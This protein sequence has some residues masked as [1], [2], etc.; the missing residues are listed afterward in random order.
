MIKKKAAIIFLAFLF[1]QLLIL[2]GQA[3]EERITNG[4][5]ETGDFTGWDQDG[6]QIEGE[7]IRTGSYSAWIPYTDSPNWLNQTLAT[8]TAVN[9][10]ESF[11][12]WIRHTPDVNEVIFIQINYTDATFT[13]FNHTTQT[14]GVWE[15]ENILAHLDSGKTVA[16]I[17]FYITSQPAFQNWFI[18]DVSLLTE[19]APPPT[20]QEDISE[21]LELAAALMVALWILVFIVHMI[22][23]LESGNSENLIHILMAYIVTM[24]II[25]GLASIMLSI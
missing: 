19:G 20:A 10:T 11:T 3:Q 18:D 23:M 15:E 12:C 17:E 1:A 14:Q 8:P 21:N 24:L 4:G 6:C 16:E 13:L 22:Y 2:P 7:E 9:D 5:F 25:L